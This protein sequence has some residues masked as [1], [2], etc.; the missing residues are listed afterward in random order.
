VLDVGSYIIA[1]KGWRKPKDYAEVIEILGEQNVLP[2]DLA[3][4]IVG[5]A[6][7]RNILVHAYL[8]IDRDVL[9]E[10]LEMIDDFRT[11]QRH[12]LQSIS[13]SKEV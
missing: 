4:K 9:Y 1:G 10:K 13:E 8:R 7:L 6:N 3:N 12:I 11:F 5:M 2:H